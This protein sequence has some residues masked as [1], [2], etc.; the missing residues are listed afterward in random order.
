[1]SLSSLHGFAIGANDGRTFALIP[2]VVPGLF[3]ALAGEL[4]VGPEKAFTGGRH[5][6]I[7]NV[8]DLWT[9]VQKIGTFPLALLQC[10]ALWTWKC[11]LL[12]AF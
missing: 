8:L 1:M 6:V 7:E 3:L 11:C 4:G 5:H 2:F 12:E 10:P 9:R